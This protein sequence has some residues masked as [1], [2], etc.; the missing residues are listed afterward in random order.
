MAI[1]LALF[2]DEFTSYK[3]WHNALLQGG[4]IEP[5]LVSNKPDELIA[6]ERLI[7]SSQ[8]PLSATLSLFSQYQIDAVIQQRLAANKPTLLAGAA[9]HAALAGGGQ[10]DWLGLGVLPGV[11][12]PFQAQRNDVG[13]R[14]KTPHLGWNALVSLPPHPLWAGIS[15]GAFAYFAH[16]YYVDQIP[17]AAQL[18]RVHH[19]I[20]FP[21][22]FYQHSLCAVQFRPE[23]SARTGVQ[24]LENFLRW[25]P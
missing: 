6:A 10:F 8:R 2:V 14:V 11:L 20:Y 7:I 13:E 17:P 19:G 1:R 24:F 4:L 21:A 22:V 23:I 5:P 16:Q 25:R 12:A 9:V 15:E 18:A 3:H